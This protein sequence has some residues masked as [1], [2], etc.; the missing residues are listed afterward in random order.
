MN[1]TFGSGSVRSSSILL[2]LF[3]PFNLHSYDFA[4]KSFCKQL[5]KS[6]QSYY[7]SGNISQIF[8]HIKCEATEQK[9]QKMHVKIKKKKRYEEHNSEIAYWVREL[10]WMHL[11]AIQ[12]KLIIARH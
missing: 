3:L 7:S 10:A 11:L 2:L 8:E 9:Q 1:S 4:A 5:Q 6:N 12:C